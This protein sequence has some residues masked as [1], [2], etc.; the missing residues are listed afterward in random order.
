ME[1]YI[2]VKLHDLKYSVMT[3]VDP[4]SGRWPSQS[5]QHLCE[6]A[7]RCL[8]IKLKDRA[9]IEDVRLM[10]ENMVST[11]CF[12]YRFILDWKRIYVKELLWHLCLKSN[13]ISILKNIRSLIIHDVSIY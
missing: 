12:Y 7:R 1:P 4:T 6:I 8:E 3:K 2:A 9:S 11:I 13:Y 10:Y 5:I